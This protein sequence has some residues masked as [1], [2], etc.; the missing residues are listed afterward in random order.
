MSTDMWRIK[1][2]Q[3]TTFCYTASKIMARR[4]MTKNRQHISYLFGSNNINYYNTDFSQTTY[5]KTSGLKFTL[6]WKLR[7]NKNLKHLY[8]F[9]H[10]LTNY[11]GSRDPFSKYQECNKPS[12]FHKKNKTSD[13]QV[14]K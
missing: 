7:V 1:A 12:G 11:L 5:A 6:K 13:T 9:F 10:L 3:L 4:A 8:H 14:I 2:E